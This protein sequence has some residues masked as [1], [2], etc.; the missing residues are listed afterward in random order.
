M[1]HQSRETQRTSPIISAMHER[2]C[3]I[4]GATSGI[5]RSTAYELARLENTV[6]L[7]G[8]D[9]KKCAATAENIVRT[10]GNRSVD[11]LVADLSSQDDI[12]ALARQFLGK[13]SR[14]DVLVNNAGTIAW[15]RQSSPDGIELTF[16]VNH[17]SYFLLTNL[18][19]DILRSSTPSRI[20]NVSS[21]AHAGVELDLDD[22]QNPKRYRALQAY[23]R[24][25]LANLLFTY[26]LASRLE[27][28]GVTVNAL[29][30]GLV[31]TNLA[32]N[33]KMPLGWISRP[34]LRSAL[35]IAG[36][37]V[38]Q[39]NRTLVYLATAEDV[40]GITGKYFVDEAET[41]SSP[42]SYDIRMA[43]LLWELS[44]RLTDHSPS[45]PSTRNYSER[46]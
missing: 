8:R 16:A 18:L 14:L 23:G 19:T 34:I 38:V 37:K 24:S 28:S 35:A 46:T 15:T 7:V 44:D 41:N 26:E 3:L 25:K 30:P 36:R 1:Q 11:Y 13:Y 29:H 5:G 9:K 27:S 4:T 33:G 31:A 32:S 10:T 40:A 12:L 22:V 45:G 21:V 42:A 39:G 6:V 20:I 2:V 17:L 43:S